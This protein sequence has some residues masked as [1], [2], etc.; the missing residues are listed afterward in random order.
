MRGNVKFNLLLSLLTIIVMA[1]LGLI[2]DVARFFVYNYQQYITEY[3]T[4]TISMTLIGF[5]I[6]ATQ[7]IKFYLSKRER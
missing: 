7:V 2:I 5:V 6:S 1:A 3:F 4:F